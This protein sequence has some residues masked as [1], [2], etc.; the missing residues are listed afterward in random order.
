MIV[1]LKGRQGGRQKYD[2]TC[3]GNRR[4]SRREM[5]LSDN[6]NAVV[7]PRISCAMTSLILLTLPP[8]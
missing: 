4:M 2:K 1:D 5:K 3:Q 7:S 6:Q 8:H